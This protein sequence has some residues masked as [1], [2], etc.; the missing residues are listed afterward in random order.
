M[1]EIEK[2]EKEIDCINI[3]RIEA[4]LTEE[5]EDAKLLESVHEH[6]KELLSIKKKELKRR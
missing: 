4:S 6:L 2:L 1:D 5:Y 3:K